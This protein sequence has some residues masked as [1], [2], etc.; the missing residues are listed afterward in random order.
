MEGE[1]RE[2]H[3]Q[4]ALERA[5]RAEPP[6][7]V[8]DLPPAV[9]AVRLH[10]GLGDELQRLLAAELGADRAHELRAAQGGWPWGRS[11]SRTCH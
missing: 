3:R 10:A 4:V 11:Y 2:A 8:G 5:G 7:S 9:Q 1:V 6:A